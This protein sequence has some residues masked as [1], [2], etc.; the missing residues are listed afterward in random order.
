MQNGHIYWIWICFT[1]LF[2]YSEGPGR[3]GLYYLAGI[4]LIVVQYC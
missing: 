2:L 3:P 4:E 1:A